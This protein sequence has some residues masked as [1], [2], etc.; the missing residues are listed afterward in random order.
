MTIES[1]DFERETRGEDL[2]SITV[3]EYKN[4]PADLNKWLKSREEVPVVVREKLGVIDPQCSL[5]QALI[6]IREAIIAASEGKTARPQSLEESR[7]TS[8]AEIVE[9]GLVSCGAHTRA[10]GTVLRS[11][12]VP[13]RFVDGIHTEDNETHDHAWLDIYVPKTNGWVESDTRT[14]NFTLGPGNT[15]NAVFHDWEELRVKGR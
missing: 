9:R 12:G 7:F 13:V 8:F 1:P 4:L 5:R 15:R 10:I 11:H 6:Q 3:G 14:E 2:D